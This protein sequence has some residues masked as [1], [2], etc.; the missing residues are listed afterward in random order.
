ML[1]SLSPFYS[2]QDPSPRDGATQF[3]IC[4]PFSVN[5]VWKLPQMCLEACLLGESTPI[6]SQGCPAGHLTSWG[7]QQPVPQ[8]PGLKEGEGRV[9]SLLFSQADTSSYSWL[10]TLLILVRLLSG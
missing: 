6:D 5:L 9:S 2:V 8:G 10:S 7:G 3:W 1:T 4:L